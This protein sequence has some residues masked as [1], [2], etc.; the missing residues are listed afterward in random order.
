[1]TQNAEADWYVAQ[2]KPN[3]FARAV[4]NLARQGFATFMPMQNR[5]IRHA[6]QLKNVMR[7]VFP[8]YLF[9][10]F[11]ADRADW[12]KI[13]STFGVSRLVSFSES[14]PTPVPSALMA[15][16]LARCDAQN[17]L[18]APADLKA[19]EKVRLLSGAFA[20]FVG[21]VETLIGDESVRVLL[22]IMGQSARLDVPRGQVGRMTD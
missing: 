12:R 11:G 6:R 3:G 1:M 4:A 8:G 19:G 20:D 7:P 18:Q 22:D 15:G 17:I 16:L 2:L 13:N 21:E 9:V 14:Q 5:T 10:Q